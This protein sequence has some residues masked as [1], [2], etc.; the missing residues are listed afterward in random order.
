MIVKQ[1][2]QSIYISQLE[3]LHRRLDPSHRLKG[4]IHDTLIKELSGIK[5]ENALNYYLNFL[6]E[7]EYLI[8]HNLRIKDSNNHF[9]IDT[10]LLCERFIILIESKNWYGTLFFDGE[11]QVI[12]VGDNGKEEGLP[13]PIPQVKT[14]RHRLQNWLNQHGFPQI[15]LLYFVAISFPSTIIKQLYPAKP[16]PKEVIHSNSLYFEIEKLNNE[17]G[18]S[19]IDMDM[20]KDLSSKLVE[21]NEPS[22]VNILEKFKISKNELITGVVC[23]GCAGL[24][25]GRLHGKWYCVTCNLL[26]KD[27]HISLLQDY[28]LLIGDV[29]TNRE[30]RAFLMVDSPYVTKRILLDN[31]VSIGDNGMRKYKIN[32]KSR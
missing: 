17:Y 12:R 15:P 9:E 26:S 27:A 1:R 2:E 20:L 18:T 28:R 32:C 21:A 19:I 6:P 30:A 22:V 3:A 4:I 25:M 29:I 5:G 8:L 10:L 11:K 7:D 23:P 16:I 31:C 14:Q 13:N 24:P